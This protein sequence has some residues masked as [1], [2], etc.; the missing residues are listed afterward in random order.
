MKRKGDFETLLSKAMKHYFKK[1]SK[2]EAI[3]NKIT[4]HKKDKNSK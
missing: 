3:E 2:K 1:I 4:S